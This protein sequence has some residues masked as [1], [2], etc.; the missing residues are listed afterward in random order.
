M[1]VASPAVCMWLLIA[2]VLVAS[3]GS[4]L[5]RDNASAHTP[6]GERGDRDRGGSGYQPAIAA[7]TAACASRCACACR[8][9]AHRHHRAA[10]GAHWRHWDVDVEVIVDGDDGDGDGDRTRKR[11]TSAHCAASGEVRAQVSIRRY[12]F[13]VPPPPRP[14]APAPFFS[15]GS[16]AGSKSD[17]V[18][19][20]MMAL[21][22]CPCHS[23]G[24]G[25]ADDDDT[26]GD[27]GSTN[28]GSGDREDSGVGAHTDDTGKDT[29]GDDCD[30]DPS[31]FSVAPPRLALSVDDDSLLD[32]ILTTGQGDLILTTGDADA[33]PSRG[34]PPGRAPSTTVPVRAGRRTSRQ[35]TWLASLSQAVPGGG[36]GKLGRGSDSESKSDSEVTWVPT[37]PERDWA[38]AQRRLDARTQKEILQYLQRGGR[39]PVMGGPQHDGNGG[40]GG[41]VALVVCSTTVRARVMVPLGADAGGQHNEHFD[42]K[43]V[44]D[45]QIRVCVHTTPPTCMC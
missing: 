6:D 17:V 29:E 11:H 37:P 32:L 8:A 1:G 28:G 12:T 34:G 33:D 26:D 31:G 43:C 16:Q 13:S 3:L 42:H 45:R 9:G 23:G 27:Q 39:G 24:G 36:L 44:L 7:G 19:A 10:G 40:E 20:A 38:C 22:L 18:L 4:P 41:R 21:P 5:A 14:K 2:A 35:A 30:C 15:L 25:D